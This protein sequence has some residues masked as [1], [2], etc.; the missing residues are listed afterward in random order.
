[1]SRPSA[2]GDPSGRNSKRCSP[3]NANG[4]PAAQGTRE[5]ESFHTGAV[6]N[7]EFAGRPGTSSTPHHA[8]TGWAGRDLDAPRPRRRMTL[9]GSDHSRRNESERERD[10]NRRS[11]GL[12]SRAGLRSAPCDGGSATRTIHMSR[13]ARL[14]KTSRDGGAEWSRIARVSARGGDTEGKPARSSA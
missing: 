8:V 7:L 6:L 11:V 13:R 12:I 4:R 9:H 10:D 5:V 1:M 2:D 14:A 3:S